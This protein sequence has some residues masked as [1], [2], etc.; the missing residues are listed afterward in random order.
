M[1]D[2]LAAFLSGQLEQ[3]QVVQ[4]KRR[5]IWN[6]YDG[7]LRDWAARHDV[8]TPIVPGHCEQAYHMY[9]LLMPSAASRDAMIA[10]LRSRGIL[11][12]F[13]YLPLHLSVMGRKFGGIA[14]DCPVTESISDRL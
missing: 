2:A 8:R 7:A 4:Q 11:A 14:G 12:V 9:Y 5:Q 6:R 10:H 3:W 1:S 13:H